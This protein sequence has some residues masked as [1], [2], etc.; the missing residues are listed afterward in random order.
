MVALVSKPVSGIK[1][2]ARVP[3]DKSISHRAL[4]LGAIAEGETVISGLLEGEDVLRTA[5]ALLSMGAI[6]TPPDMPGGMWR[7]QGLTKGASGA[8]ILRPPRTALDLGN[9]GTSAR[10]LMGLI[11]GYS[12]TAVLTGDASL[13][14]RPMGRVIKPLSQM[15]AQFEA[16][17]G[18]KMP[19]RVIGAGNLRPISYTLPVPSAQV[20]SAIMLAGLRAGGITMIVEPVPT[21]DHSERMLRYFGADI[22][23]QAQPDGSNVVTVTGGAR[24]TGRQVTVPS[25]PS[26]AAFVAVAALITE[27]SDIVI[28]NVSVNPLRVGLYDTLKEMG[29]N[30]AFENPREKSGEPVADLRVK[31]SALRGVVVPA[32]RVASMI[33]EF[34]ILA[35]A[36]AF[37]Q[38]KTVMTD[39][40]ELRVKES[41][42][43]LAIVRGL[44]AAGVKADMGEDSLTVTGCDGVPAG[45]CVVETQ[46]D[47]RIAMSFLVLGMAAKLP[48]TVDDG[49]TINTSFPGFTALMNSLGAAILDA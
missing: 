46:L 29:A 31:S 49:E 10:L 41:D 32:A 37:A 1:G 45:G 4:M 12:V 8:I 20:K 34:P 39:L 13:T 6:I 33:D 30:I 48:V 28:S 2:I 18:D 11:S 17:S 40:A 35:I 15:G 14:K 26:S 42:R 38:G 9:S 25:D 5:R 24:L 44:S 22:L 3:G 43:L 21:R 47:H 36:A 27:D 23:S 19:I 16:T 7:A